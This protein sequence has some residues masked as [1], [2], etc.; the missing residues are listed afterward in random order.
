[1]SSPVPYPSSRPWPRWSSWSEFPSPPLGVE[2]AVAD[3]RSM[4][5]QQN[6][7]VT[8]ACLLPPL[9]HLPQTMVLPGMRLNG[10]LPNG[11]DATKED[12][13]GSKAAEV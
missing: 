6:A 12:V 7:R 2:L 9:T 8:A 11:D 1:M 4:L 3:T 13:V 5:L 10:T